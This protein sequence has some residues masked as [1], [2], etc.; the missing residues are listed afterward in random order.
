[1]KTLFCEYPGRV[2]ILVEKA[3]RKRTKQALRFKDAVAALRWCESYGATLVY[4]PAGRMT[5]S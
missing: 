1:M 4:F 5:L 2:G 3:G